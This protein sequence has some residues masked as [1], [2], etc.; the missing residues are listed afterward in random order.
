MKYAWVIWEVITETL[1]AVNI[2]KRPINPLPPLKPS[3]C[4]AQV[5]A[6]LLKLTV[7]DVFEY[8]TIGH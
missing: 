4:V 6:I 8:I 1:L 2:W 7:L 3:V 5:V